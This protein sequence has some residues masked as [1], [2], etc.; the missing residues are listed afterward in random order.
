[1]EIKTALWLI[2]P[3][4]IFLLLVFP[5]FLEVRVS[6]NPLVNRG[7]LGVF[8]FNKKIVYYFI[9]IY[10]KYIVLKNDAE[11]KKEEI[12]FQSPK[13]LVIEEFIRQV[14]DKLRVKHMFIY[15]NIGMSDAFLSGMICAFLNQIINL[16]FVNLKS[17]KP[18]ASLCL[19]DTVSY[20]RVICE[21]A[22]NAKISISLFDLVYSFIYSSIITKSRDVWYMVWY[23]I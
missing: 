15:Y 8:I 23:A 17:K 21:L 20:N 7:A 13:F 16:F 10:G 2:I 19:Y 5:I 22:M 1:M 4:F 12:E 18:T 14:K 6:F 9:E 11:T 3:A